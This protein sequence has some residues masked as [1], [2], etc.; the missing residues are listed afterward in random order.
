MHV[1]DVRVQAQECARAA[2][3]VAAG[4]SMDDI[5]PS[6]LGLK[7]NNLVEVDLWMHPHQASPCPIISFGGREPTPTIVRH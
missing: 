2:A 5:P 1:L 7:M 4:I 6:T 3:Q